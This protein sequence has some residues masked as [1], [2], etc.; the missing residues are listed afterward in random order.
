MAAL[1]VRARAWTPRPVWN[2]AR[3]A[4]TYLRR[5]GDWGRVLARLR[6]DGPR[7]TLKLW[8]SALAAPVTA[9][10]EL[11]HWGH[12]VGL[13]DTGV[14]AGRGN[15]FVCRRRT[16]DLAHALAGRDGSLWPAIAR[17]LAPGG[18]FV[19]A[20]ANI[21]GLTVPAARLVGAGA[22]VVA[23]EM[24]PETAA[25]LRHHLRLNRLDWVRVVEGALSDREGA[26]VTASMPAGNHGQA[27][28]AAGAS[29]RGPRVEVAVRTL[30][31]DRVL[32]DLGRID[33]L[34]L[35]LE[36][37]EVLALAGGGAVLARTRCVIFEDW[38]GRD[39][40][41]LAAELIAAAGFRLSRVDGINLMGVR[42]EV[43]AAHA[44]MPVR[45]GIAGDIEGIPASAR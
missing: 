45:A 7:E 44:V 33:V 35:D 19:D 2:L 38:G 25:Q 40:G 43:A 30:T 4:H 42:P 5:L 18:V 23:I 8:L 12:P 9:L 39:P 16:D 17:H 13:F 31:L 34:K 26:Q 29:R 3:R 41:K 14:E 37:A 10:R 24:M 22:Q 1:R 6:G 21:G 36:G 27:S 15:R 28:I 11:D 32:A 20:G